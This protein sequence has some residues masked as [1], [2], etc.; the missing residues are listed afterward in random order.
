MQIY[1]AATAS[2]KLESEDCPPPVHGSTFYNLLLTTTMNP[3]FAFFSLNFSSPASEDPADLVTRAAIFISFN[4]SFKSP[5]QLN[6]EPFALRSSSWAGNTA[7][8]SQIKIALAGFKLK[9][10]SN[11]EFLKK[12][13]RRCFGC[14]YGTFIPIND[15]AGI[16]VNKEIFEN[17]HRGMASLFSDHIFHFFS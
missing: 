5:D 4:I 6:C 8:D 14:F 16:L 17:G 10:E 9:L 3:S 15:V 7:R 2:H 11:C 1:K 13:E 12:K